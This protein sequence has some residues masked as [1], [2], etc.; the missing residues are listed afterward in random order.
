MTNRRDELI[1]IDRLA[2]VA[3]RMAVVRRQPVGRDEQETLL[4]G[5]VDVAV[6]GDDVDLHAVDDGLADR[7][8]SEVR[9]PP[10]GQVEH[11]LRQ[12]RRVEQR[13]RVERQRLHH[14]LLVRQFMQQSELIEWREADNHV[15]MTG[16]IAVEFEG[17]LV[18]PQDSL[19]SVI[20]TRPSRTSSASRSSSR[21]RSARPRAPRALRGCA[22][23]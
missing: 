11:G 17:E 15:I 19:R 9:Q 20:T 5:G 21:R 13:V 22:G 18:V 16:A 4:T 1:V 14:A 12:V 3:V 6:A 23:P 10:R 8:Q 2:N 7:R